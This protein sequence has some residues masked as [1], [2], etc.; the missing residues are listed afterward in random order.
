MAACGSKTAPAARKAV[1][2]LMA[3][4]G[5]RRSAEACCALV[6]RAYVFREL[7]L[8]GEKALCAWHPA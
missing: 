2:L 6:Q 8:L 7:A 5:S 4:P 1:K 3:G